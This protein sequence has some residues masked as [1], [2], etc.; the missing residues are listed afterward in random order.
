MSR[1]RKRGVDLLLAAAVILMVSGCSLAPSFVRPEVPLEESWVGAALLAQEA[2]ERAGGIAVRDL[3]W[4][5][6]FQD[7][8]LRQLIALALNNNH[9]LKKAALNAELA[10]A[11]YRITRSER[12]PGVAGNGA[13]TKAR[14]GRDSSFSGSARTTTSYRVG[15]GISAFELDFFGRVKNL[16]A[17]K[18]NDYLRTCEARDSA[19]L[20]VISA[21]ATAYYE[22]RTDRELMA[23][24]REVAKVRRDAWELTKLQVEAGTATETTLQGMRSAIELAEVDYQV[25][26]RAFLHARNTLSTLIGEPVTGLKLAAERELDRQFPEEPVAAGIPSEVLLARPD[27]RA[28]EYALK[29]ANANIGVAR[30]AFFPRISLTGSLGFASSDLGDLFDDENTNWS[31]GPELSLPLFDYG[32][33][34]A[35]VEAMTIRQQIAVENYAS[36]LQS[37]FAEIDNALAARETL[38][39][40][41]TAMV[42]SDK[43]V[44]RRLHLIDMQLKEGVVDGMA[45]LDAQRESFSSRQALYKTAQ[46]ILNNQVD[47]YIALGG[48]L[49]EFTGEAAGRV[50]TSP[51]AK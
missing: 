16:S 51:A 33:R 19:E 2:R 3:G 25:E 20:A 36:V 43:A 28:A 27:I 45:L 1:V 31:F 6:Y 30:A 4:R 10:R 7:P 17:A 37:A 49:N 12:L 38:A 39:K 21:V 35:N 15:L 34:A 18:L 29:A 5:D 44:A 11:Q 26:K 14:T 22:M 8:Q 40:Q 41:L 24:A 48:G 46:Q 9:D 23:L 50:A 42:I 47:L 13:V 32:R